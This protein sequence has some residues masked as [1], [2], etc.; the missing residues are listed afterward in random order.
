MEEKTTKKNLGEDMLQF[1]IKLYEVQEQIK[2]TYKIKE[3]S[4]EKD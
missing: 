1:I 3:K 2:V 4:N